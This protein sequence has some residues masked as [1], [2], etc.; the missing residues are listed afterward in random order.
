MNLEKL[1]FKELLAFHT[2][3]EEEWRR[4]EIKRTSNNFTGDLAEHLFRKAFPSWKWPGNSNAGF[5]AIDNKGVKYQ[6]KG[7][8]CTEQN[9]SR[10][11][12]AIR[13]L[14]DKDKPFN[15]L[16]AVIFSEDYGI[17]Q[18]ALIPYDVVKRRSPKVQTHTN[19]HRFLLTKDVWNEA[20]VEDI[21]EKLK[22]AV[23]IS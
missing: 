23:E 16:A 17:Q 14:E 7:R 20:G 1:S 2:G 9:K 15:V 12:G 22:K 19:S 5:D 10:Q 21:T 18:A 6:I 8:R 4:R 13:N 3:L 11:L